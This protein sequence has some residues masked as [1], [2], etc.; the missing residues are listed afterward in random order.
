ML[1]PFEQ[2][3]SH[4]ERLPPPL[5]VQNDQDRLMEAFVG[6]QYH[7]YYKEKFDLITAKKSIAGF[8]I[9]AFLLGVMWLFYRKMYVYGV[10][11][12]ALMIGLGMLED[13]LEISGTGSSIGMAVAFGLVGNT[14][15]KQFA[16]KK[17]NALQSE[18]AIKKAG[19]TNIWAGLAIFVIGVLLFI[20]GSFA[21]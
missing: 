3:E 7:E 17:I 16:E 5:P 11:A 9:A 15:Y 8:N 13:Y 1:S 2:Q 19:G 21:E 20:L 10:A 4:S 14:L 18:Q 6:K 12:I